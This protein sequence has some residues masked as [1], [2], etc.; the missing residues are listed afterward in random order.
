M[1][2]QISA[3][4][5]ASVLGAGALVWSAPTPANAALTIVSPCQNTDITPTASAC[6]GWYAGNLLN[7]TAVGDQQSALATLGFT[8]DGNWNAVD[9]T[10]VDAVGSGFDF[11]S[12]LHTGAIIG[13]KI[14]AA[15]FG[16]EA[17]GFFKLAQNNIDIVTLN[18]QGASSAVVYTPGVIPEPATWG[19]MILGVG[20][21]GAMLRRKRQEL[22]G[23]ATA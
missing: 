20:A 5:A 4:V 12:L 8:W 21:V 15:Q 11:A 2:S 16:Q 18:L 14:G 10:K 17:T 3:L 6:A 1:K 23:A 9:A 13:I 7:Q 22:D 19:L